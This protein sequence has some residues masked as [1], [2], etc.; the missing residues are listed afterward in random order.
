MG[1][2]RSVTMAPGAATTPYN[3]LGGFAGLNAALGQLNLNGTSGNPGFFPFLDHLC[4]DPLFGFGSP[5]NPLASLPQGGLIGSGINPLAG[6][7]NFSTGSS[8]LGPLALPGPSFNQFHSSGI[9]PLAG[10]PPSSFNSFQSS[11]IAPLAVLPHL[12]GF[13]QFN[14]FPMSGFN[15][16]FNSG[17]NQGFN[18]GFG[19][20]ISPLAGCGIGPLAHPCNSS[21]FSSFPQINPPQ[22]CFMQ[23]CGPCIQKVPVPV[24]QPYSVPFPVHIPVKVN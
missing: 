5:L 18:S 9:S 6:L 21:P 14:G 13:N 10:L 22:S 11:G 15:T 19:S 20:G 8:G 12:P 1:A 7:P 3:G 2:G 17:F 23:S 16:S 4:S 24:P